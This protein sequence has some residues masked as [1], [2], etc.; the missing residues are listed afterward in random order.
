MAQYFGE[1]PAQNLACQPAT[2]EAA[3]KAI[4]YPPDPH[5]CQE[6]HAGLPSFWKKVYYWQVPVADCADSRGNTGKDYNDWS[7]AWTQIKG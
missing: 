4:G 6:Y 5:F 7:A 2:L 1:A 3:A